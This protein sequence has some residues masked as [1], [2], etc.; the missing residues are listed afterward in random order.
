VERERLGAESSIATEEREL[1]RILRHERPRVCFVREHG[2]RPLRRD[3]TAGC[4]RIL[5]Q[6]LD[7][8]PCA[9]RRVA[10]I[11]AEAAADID[12]HV[13]H[14]GSGVVQS[15]I[16]RKMRMTAPCLSYPTRRSVSYADEYASR[17]F[18]ALSATPPEVRSPSA[19][20]QIDTRWDAGTAREAL[21][22]NA[23]STWDE[24]AHDLVMVKTGPTAY[25][26]HTR[27]VPRVRAQP[28]QVRWRRLPQLV[29]WRATRCVKIAAAHA[30]LDRKSVHPFSNPYQHHNSD[31]GGP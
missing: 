22:E 25:P 4:E 31:R 10:D 17:V 19:T 2:T 8:L 1:P 26:R 24:K 28:V 14:D 21:Y 5:Q 29:S 18:M 9:T 6:N 7:V 23:P 30:V 15:A 20:R 13:R 16:S 11:N 3:P 12:A 27:E